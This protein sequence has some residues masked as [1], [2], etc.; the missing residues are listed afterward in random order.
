MKST[1][2]KSSWLEGDYAYVAKQTKYGIY[3][4]IV[5]V[6]EED[7]DIATEWDGYRFAEYK[8]DIQYLNERAKRF[9]ERYLGIRM[10][11]HNLIQ[12]MS[13][14]EI[15]SNETI[16]KLERQMKL[17]KRD[18][19]IA[20]EECES[21]REYYKYYCDH[22]IDERKRLHEWKLKRQEALAAENV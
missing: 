13:D 2:V 6:N 9:Y 7:R 17:A 14:E 21:M 18:A 10:A 15:A 16:A 20:R 11:Y 12:S 5:D 1:I 4:A 19:A 8:C 3:E 22:I